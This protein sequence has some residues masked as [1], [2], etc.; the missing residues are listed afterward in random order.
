M[1][2]N[3]QQ[4]V[5]DRW[6][7]KE[8]TGRIVTDREH[9][10]REPITPLNTFQERLQSALKTKKVVIVDAAAGTGKSLLCGS[11]ASDALRDGR[12]NKLIL[13]RPNVLMGPTIGLLPGEI[14]E[15]MEPLLAPLVEVIIDRQGK[16]WYENQLRLGNIEFLPL[17]YA[18]GKDIKGIL[19]VDEFQNVPPK[20][21]F[22]IITR[23]SKTGK[24]L[25]LGDSTQRDLPGTTGLQFL[26]W[27]LQ[28]ADMMD[29]VAMLK[30]GGKYC[31][32][33]D[34]VKKAV[35]EMESLAAEGFTFSELDKEDL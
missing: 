6:A 7:K 13:S 28:R 20:D 26:A 24:L 8:E 15:K 11:Y 9:T 27:F 16:G 35:L 12:V 2:R 30:A 21:S 33:D 25:L 32:R 17:E 29:E 3:K 14:R 31:V 19:V 5:D 4:V 22:T 1:K 23:V 34:F 10:I 18:R